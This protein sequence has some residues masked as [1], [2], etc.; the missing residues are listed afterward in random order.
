MRGATSSVSPPPSTSE[1]D[2]SSEATNVR[3]PKSRQISKGQAKKNAGIATNHKTGKRK[4]QNVP[5]SSEDEAP[6]R[7]KKARKQVSKLDLDRA[8]P[9]P[10]NMQKTARQRKKPRSVIPRALRKK[11][12][13][14]IKSHSPPSAKSHTGSRPADDVNRPV[15]SKPYRSHPKGTAEYA[16]ESHVTHG[17]S[18]EDMSHVDSPHKLR[19][20]SPEIPLQNN[21]SLSSSCVSSDVESSMS[22][23]RPSNTT[24]P[25]HDSGSSQQEELSESYSEED[26]KRT[27]LKKAIRQKKMKAAGLVIDDILKMRNRSSRAVLYD[28]IGS[29]KGKKGANSPKRRLSL[30]T[31]DITP[32][33]KSK[34]PELSRKIKPFAISAGFFGSLGTN[35]AGSDKNEEPRPSLMPLQSQMKV[36]AGNK[37]P[38]VCLSSADSGTDDGGTNKDGSDNTSKVPYIK[39]SKRQMSVQLDKEEIKRWIH[40]D[41]HIIQNPEPTL[42]V[43]DLLVQ[44]NQTETTADID[45][46]DHGRKSSDTTLVQQPHEKGLQESESLADPLVLTTSNGGEDTDSDSNSSKQNGN[47]SDENLDEPIDVLVVDAMDQDSHSNGAKTR[48]DELKQTFTKIKL[49]DEDF[50]LGGSP[51]PGVGDD[52]A[53]DSEDDSSSS[54]GETKKQSSKQS[55]RLSDE[56]LQEPIDVVAFDDNMSNT[57]DE[58]SSESG[59]EK[60][61]FNGKSKPKTTIIKLTDDDFTTDSS[62]I[63]DVGGGAIVNMEDDSS[64]KEREE[65]YSSKQM[66][67]N[68]TGTGRDVGN[69]DPRFLP[70]DLL[71]AMSS[72]IGTAAVIGEGGSE[73]KQS[74]K[75]K[76]TKKRSIDQSSLRGVRVVLNALPLATSN[77]VIRRA[78]INVRSKISKAKKITTKKRKIGTIDDAGG[79]DPA[80]IEGKLG[81]RA[82]HRQDSKPSKRRKV[83]NQV[84]E[85][86]RDNYFQDSDDIVVK[87]LVDDNSEDYSSKR[88]KSKKKPSERKFTKPTD[89]EGVL[90]F[91]PLSGPLGIASSTEDDDCT[92]KA[93]EDSGTGSVSSGSVATNSTAQLLSHTQ[94]KHH[95]KAVRGVNLK[96]V[97]IKPTTQISHTRQE[98]HSKTIGEASSESIV[99]NPSTHHQSHTQQEEHLSKTIGEAVSELVA[100]YCTT[101]YISHTQQKE[102][103]SRTIGEVSSES[104]ETNPTSHSSHIQE[105]DRSKTIGKVSSESIATK[106]TTQHRSHTR[107]NEHRSKTIGEMSS[108]SVAMKPTCTTHQSH[109]QEERHSKITG[110]VAACSRAT[111]IGGGTS[112]ETTTVDDSAVGGATV[113]MTS[114]ST[115]TTEDKET[116]EL[117]QPKR[118]KTLLNNKKSSSGFQLS[119]VEEKKVRIIHLV[120]EPQ[121]WVKIVVYIHTY[122][123]VMVVN[124]VSSVLDRS[125]GWVEF[126]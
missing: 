78:D 95:S 52:A 63:Q 79:Y 57:E 48:S 23:Y 73:M 86:E 89:E 24:P 44:G 83:T 22:E 14:A 6:P 21:S 68:H 15:K 106:P 7:L 13:N 77:S 5:F 111:L 97:A 43:A 16:A 94:K 59:E 31:R 108:E 8:D 38:L 1:Q 109:I 120:H 122:M 85:H 47:L 62:L 119:I 123:L 46:A 49:T 126:H 12:T 67:T 121:H 60:L 76:W 2:S 20:I 50:S 35:K 80:R 10:E 71:V 100:K 75:Q 115:S 87:D 102:Y 58:E 107:E 37:A 84:Y 29:P 82:R 11:Q 18:G 56:D 30:I 32:K 116:M 54:S 88:T 34:G 117:F 98:H 69:H 74:S 66:S 105:E 125:L 17:D 27:K 110:E 91:K 65:R 40:E 3:I 90:Y 104:I 33:S 55:E 28:C 92:N 96:T 39:S 64:S 51:T 112:R 101:H 4:H 26:E 19:G 124:V 81:K 113:T 36:G 45:R 118:R 53:T 99:T 72:G 61:N 42:E 25:P 103:S 9:A 41:H 93:G 70:D 114:R